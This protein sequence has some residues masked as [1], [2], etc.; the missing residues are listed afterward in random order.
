MD[1]CT[2]ME[3]SQSRHR[4]PRGQ[5][6]PAEGSP[7]PKLAVTLP[8]PP[9]VA[10]PAVRSGGVPGARAASAVLHPK[11]RDSWARGSSPRVE[12]LTLPGCCMRPSLPSGTCTPANGSLKPHSPG[13][14]RCWR[15]GR[16]QSQTV[17]PALQP[18]ASLATGPT[19]HA[20][21]SGM[22]FHSCR[23]WGAPKGEARGNQEPQKGFG[24]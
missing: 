20:P 16:G 1:N 19:L 23:G 14:C 22:G 15:G 18:Q 2:S 12:G 10:L 5:G 9:P 13:E 7:G 3:N 11:P 6:G 17:P 24:H 21:P 8:R 4:G